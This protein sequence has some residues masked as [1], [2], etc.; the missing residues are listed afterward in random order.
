MID[1][2]LG[3]RSAIYCIQSIIFI[4]GIHYEVVH[5]IISYACKFVLSVLVIFIVAYFILTGT[6]DIMIQDLLFILIG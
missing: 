6:L 1:L 5:D 3:M 2:L 4:L